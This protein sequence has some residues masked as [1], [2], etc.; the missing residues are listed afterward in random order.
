MFSNRKYRLVTLIGA[1]LVSLVTILTPVTEGS[2]ATPNTITY[3]EI[4]GASPNYIFPFAGCQYDTANNIAQFQRLMYRPLYWF[5]LGSSAG[6]VPALSLA[7]QPVFNRVDTALRLTIKGWKFAN[8]EVVGPLAVMFFLNMYRADPTSFCGFSQGFGIPDQLRAAKAV[9]NSVIMAFAKPVN[10]TWFLD[11]FLS[12]ITPMTSTWD[13][14]SVTQPGRCATGVYGASTTIAAC[15]NVEAYLDSFA[16][17]TA[18]F[19]NAMWQGGV[20]G[21][22]R[23]KSLD[24]V[25]NATFQPNT[26]YSGPQKAQV[27]FL[28]EVPF[29]STDQEVSALASGSID[30]GYIDPTAL[31]PRNPIGGAMGANAASLTSNYTASMGS[32]WQFNEA[33]LNFNSSNT[34]AAALAQPYIRQALQLSINQ[35]AIL[36]SVANGY[37]YTTSSP[38]PPTTPSTMSRPMADPYPF[39]LVRAKALLTSHGWAETA[40]VMICVDPGSNTNQCGAGIIAGYALNFAMVW[41]GVSAQ[42][43]AEY[44]QEIANWA[45]IGIVVTK[46][47]DTPGNIVND[48]SS[49]SPYQICGLSNGWNYGGNYFASGE[50]LFMTSGS[51]NL[52]SYS[53]VHMDALINQSI[54]RPVALT[55]YASYAARILPVIFE[56]QI[57]RITEV[58]NTLKSSVGPVSSPLQTFTPEYLHF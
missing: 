21:P 34:K 56:P 32:L 15:K 51:A 40:G 47:L 48:C 37:G 8:G 30:I 2:A 11:N 13:R 22:W 25:G 18:T 23:L 46:S 42:L 20:D 3:A 36:T 14:V 7:T 49:A 28:K 35:T 12:Q 57:A 10:P 26:A 19:T 43:N 39:S 17:K 29:N 53:D 31:G 41:P 44:Q 6:E 5:G 1:A 24:A 27:A 50:Q 9:G 38:L 45:Q 58:H 54:S 52:G 16:A 4:P 55:N 33:I